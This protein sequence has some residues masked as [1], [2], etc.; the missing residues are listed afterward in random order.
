MGT[1]NVIDAKALIV[2]YREIAARANETIKGLPGLSQ[3]MSVRVTLGKHN[4]ELVDCPLHASVDGEFAKVILTGIENFCLQ[5]AQ[6]LE[7]QV[8]AIGRR[9]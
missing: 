5:R 1:H 7:T 2:Y 9:I 3:V 8:A 4:T 6:D